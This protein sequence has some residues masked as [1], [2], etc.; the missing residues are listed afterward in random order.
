MSSR[1][2]QPPGV[3]PLHRVLWG[4]LK[5]R[6]WIAAGV[7]GGCGFLFLLFA[8]LPFFV[9]ICV[10]LPPVLVVLALACPWRGKQLDVWLMEALDFHWRALSY[11]LVARR[12]SSAAA[13]EEVEEAEGQEDAE[14]SLFLEEMEAEETPL[15]ARAT[16][17]L[18]A[19]LPAFAAAQEAR[20]AFAAAPPGGQWQAAQDGASSAA[21]RSGAGAPGWP[22]E[23]EADPNSLGPLWRADGSTVHGK[24]GVFMRA[25]QQ[26][27]AS[28]SFPTD[29][30]PSSSSTEVD[31]AYQPG[32]GWYDAGGLFLS[33]Q[34]GRSPVEG[35]G[36]HPAAAPAGKRRGRT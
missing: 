5:P 23:A 22:G 4:S 26:H 30:R 3:V 11:A 36:P 28:A 25:I 29:G 35:S 2:V 17:P 13:Q 31:L 32:F 9:R 7:A 8:P 10:A 15:E 1:L 20:A 14:D 16:A 24:A 34:S 27:L 6:Y 19:A 21:H 18:L 12:G 33:D